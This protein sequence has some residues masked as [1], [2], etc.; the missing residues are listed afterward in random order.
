MKNEADAAAL[1]AEFDVLIARA[2]LTIPTDRRA[3]LLVAFADL[4]REISRLYE[5]LAP[6][7]EPAAVYRLHSAERGQ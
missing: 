5:T 3:E 2:G 1:A 6:E 4:R 7:M